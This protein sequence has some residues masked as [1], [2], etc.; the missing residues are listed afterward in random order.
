[1]GNIYI[2]R[3]DIPKDLINLFRIN[4]E[5]SDKEVIMATY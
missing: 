4:M 2:Y 3:T 5:Y 1:M